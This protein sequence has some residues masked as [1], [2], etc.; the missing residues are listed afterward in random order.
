MEQRRKKSATRMRRK[1]PNVLRSGTFQPSPRAAG[2]T[3]SPAPGTCW[4]Q[5]GCLENGTAPIWVTPATETAKCCHGHSNQAALPQR[6]EKVPLAAI[7]I[8]AG[9]ARS[10]QPAPGCTRHRKRGGREEIMQFGVCSRTAPGSGWLFSGISHPTP[11]EL[12]IC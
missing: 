9:L 11:R 2:Q 12:A 10:R 3:P 4:A 7:P 8:R 5:Q 6:R 1:K